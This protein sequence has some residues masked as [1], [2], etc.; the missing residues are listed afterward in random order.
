M[1]VRAL[2]SDR[3][4]E[5]LIVSLGNV[6]GTPSSCAVAVSGGVDS[7]T[8][9]VIAGR[10]HDNMEMFH[11]ISPAV[12]S[13][14][15]TRVK[16]YAEQEGWRLTV[17]D[18][19]EFGDSDYRANPVNRC[20]FCKTNLYSAMAARTTRTL[21]SGTNLDDIGDF[22]PGLKAAAE[23][24]V[25]H[26]YVEASINKEGVRAMARH[27]QLDD[28]SDLPAAP[29][30][31]SRIETG[32]PIDA[33]DLTAVHAVE[34]RVRRKLNPKTVRCRV[35]ATGVVVELDEQALTVLTPAEG[36]RL[37]EAT[38]ML[39][40]GHRPQISVHFERYAMGS[41]FVNGPLSSLE[42]EV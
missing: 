2:S 13:E 14:A 16:R 42:L 7:M 9:A 25:R 23:H 24:N 19:G 5:A 28:L 20:Y 33:R 36:E 38:R 21:Y 1:A 39:F 26:P 31:S 4:A 35:R 18:A 32:I 6:I 10:Y 34:N 11:A 8:L 40:A 41:A 37:V 30:L 27:L 22:R 12:P 15:T 29:C 17:L 3:N